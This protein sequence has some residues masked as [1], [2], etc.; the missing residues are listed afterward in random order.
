M[1]SLILRNIPIIE[2]IFRRFYYRLHDLGFI[3]KKNKIIDLSK[4]KS[5]NTNNREKLEDYL[6]SL[7]IKQGDILIVHSSFDEMKNFDITPSELMCILRSLIGD[8]GTLVFPTFPI[9]KKGK[10]S[11]SI[12]DFKSKMCSTGLMPALFLRGKNVEKSLFPLNTLSASGPQAKD[13]MKDNLMTDLPHGIGSSWHYCSENHAK[14]LLLGVD[15]SKTLTMVH[16]AEDIMDE[17]WPI[18]NWYLKEDIVI[19]YEEHHIQK[20]VRYR[21]QFWSRFMVSEYRTKWLKDNGILVSTSFDG[22]PISFVQDSNKLVKSIVNNMRESKVS[23]FRPPSK[24]WKK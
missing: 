4:K 13:M 23:F 21:D 9:L 20:E 6:N 12:Y 22:I 19:R 2:I 16:V 24:H 15:P 1:M 18:K 14:I 8:D 3:G 10:Q 17:N 5:T 11:E 7:N